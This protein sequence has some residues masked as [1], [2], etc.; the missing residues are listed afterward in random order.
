MNFAPIELSLRLGGEVRYIFHSISSFS[1]LLVYEF[2]LKYAK[3]KKIGAAGA[4]GTS[5]ALTGTDTGSVLESGI[6]TDL[7]YTGT[8]LLLHQRYR[9][10]SKGVPVQV[11][12]ICPEMVNFTIFHALFF[13]N[14]L[15]WNRGVTS[16]YQSIGIR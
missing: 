9:Y 1:I 8:V 4:I 12:E 7:G 11:S 16:W 15:L 2:Y 3:I 5:I 6:G 14:S 13:H 10:S